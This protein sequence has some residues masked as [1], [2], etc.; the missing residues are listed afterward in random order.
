MR[1]CQ[2]PSLETGNR[3]SMAAKIMTQATMVV[4]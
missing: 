1:C 4:R 2:N 3:V